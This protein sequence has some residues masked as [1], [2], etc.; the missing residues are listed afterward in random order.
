MMGIIVNQ[1][2]RKPIERIDSLHFAQGTPY[3][4]LVRHAKQPVGERILSEEV[5]RA[6]PPTRFAA[7]SRRAPPSASR[8]PSRWPTARSS[9]WAARPVPATSASRCTGPVGA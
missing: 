8:L 7:W 6:P 1:G 5:A 9:P 3:E 4:T 2:V